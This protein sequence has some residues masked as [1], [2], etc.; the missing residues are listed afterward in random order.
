[1]AAKW[2]VGL[3]LAS[4]VL[5]VVSAVL[6]YRWFQ[7]RFLAPPPEFDRCHA[8]MEALYVGQPFD[9]ARDSVRAALGGD[10]ALEAPQ[11]E[12]IWRAVQT[13]AEAR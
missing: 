5:V 12:Q 8:A 2:L 4:L 10:A 13:D 7:P 6:Y 9:E 11:A 1:M 3:L